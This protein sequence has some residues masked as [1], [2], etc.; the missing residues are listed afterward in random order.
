MHLVHT[1]EVPLRFLMVRCGAVHDKG[2][3]IIAKIFVPTVVLYAIVEYAIPRLK[4]ARKLFIKADD[5][6][7]GQSD[8]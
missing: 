5:T 8:R 3:L 4:P 2:L 6:D 7:K 1:A